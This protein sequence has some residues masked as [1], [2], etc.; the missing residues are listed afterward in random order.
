MSPAA[1]AELVAFSYVSLANSL[2]SIRGALRLML[3]GPCLV[4]FVADVGDVYPGVR[5]LIHCAIAP[6]DPLVWIRI[7]AISGGV[8]MPGGHMDDGA[9]R[10]HRSC[11]VGVDVVVHPVEV[12][13]IDVA[14]HL[15]GAGGQDGFEGHGLAAQVHMRL[16]VAEN[17]WSL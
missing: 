10:Q 4:I 9:F 14:D 1:L 16:E 11:I 5:H 7:V 3:G 8:V 17:R 15:S 13:M 2:H 12:E 6:S